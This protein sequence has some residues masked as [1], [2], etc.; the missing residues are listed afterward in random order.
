MK[1]RLA[2]VL[3]ATMATLV[4]IGV[5]YKFGANLLTVAFALVLLSCPVWVVWMSLR[6][7]R[8]THHDIQNAVGKELDSRKR[9]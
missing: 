8:Q 5:L 1:R 2:S 9:F 4:A 3:C 6:L 7:S